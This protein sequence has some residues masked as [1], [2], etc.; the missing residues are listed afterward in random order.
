MKQVE[1]RIWNVAVRQSI[2]ERVKSLPDDGS[3]VV[4]IK[5]AEESRSI[6]QN[7]LMWRWFGE[8]AEETGY[9]KQDVHDIFCSQILGTKVVRRFDGM[10]VEV[11]NGTRELKVREMAD[12]LTQ[13]EA[14][15]TNMGWYLSH[16]EDSYYKAMGLI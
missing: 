9:T 4:I 13:V 5:K 15:A 8:I 16:P 7:R 14:M 2:V 3:V 12:F 11:I 1:T 6:A 10:E